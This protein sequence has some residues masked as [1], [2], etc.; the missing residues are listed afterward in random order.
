MFILLVDEQL[1]YV[2][3]VHCLVANVHHVVVEIHCVVV[4][5]GAH[6]VVVEIIH[7]WF[8]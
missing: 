3:G 6:H 7:C 4:V 5:A 1:R 2:V 8:H